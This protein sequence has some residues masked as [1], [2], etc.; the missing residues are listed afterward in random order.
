MKHPILL[1]LLAALATITTT[2]Q[3]LDDALARFNE[4]KFDESA[5]M[6]EELARKNPR[7]ADA[8]V[9]LA[10]NYRYL[11]RYTDAI[12]MAYDALALSPCNAL[13]HTVI[14][15]A[16]NPGNWPESKGAV[17]TIWKH[18]MRAIE[19]DSTAGEAWTSIWIQAQRRG[20]ATMERASLRRL[21]HDRFFTRSTL[22]GVRLILRDL[23]KGA[24]LITNGDLDTYPALAIQQEE[25]FR[26]D[27]VVVNRPMLG[28]DWYARLI[29]K[30]HRLR[31]LLNDQQL[32]TYYDEAAVNSRMKTRDDRSM[33]E[34]LLDGWLE[35]AQEGKL[36]RPVAITSV[37][38]EELTAMM[39]RGFVYK[40]RADQLNFVYNGGAEGLNT[41]MGRGFVYNG[42]YFLATKGPRRGI[43]SDTAAI[44]RFFTGQNPSDFAGASTGDRDPS[45]IRR[46]GYNF[47]TSM[48]YTIMVY[49]HDMVTSGRF[50]EARRSLELAGRFASVTINPDHWHDYL[51]EVR[52]AIERE[53]K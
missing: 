43:T 5:L 47:A 33:D 28:L 34:V 53:E 48:T 46:S 17:D 29:S 30:R 14:A 4:R 49:T 41:M 26:T 44:R 25:G 16:Y 1:L 35:R 52:A 32:A 51:E 50:D 15:D 40:G 7:D 38:A 9:W 22:N 11:K 10:L 8:K 6:F 27:V 24:I 13:A 12:D 21:Y 36:E 3:T 20:D 39:S 2:A 37:T 23:P 19:C 42:G 45:P 18:L 31:L